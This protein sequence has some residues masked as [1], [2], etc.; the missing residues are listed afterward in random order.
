MPFQIIRAD[1]TRVKVDA[2]VNSANPEPVIGRGCDG[3]IYQAAG[4]ERMLK[5]RK[6]IGPIATGDVAVTKG[7]ALPAKYVFHTVG[8]VWNGG[9]SGEFLSLAACYQKSLQKAAEMK[10]RS[11]AFP[12]IS[13]GVYGFPKD[14]ALEIALSEIQN[15]LEHS[16]IDVTL[17]VFDRKAYEISDARMKD[18]AA[19][20]DDTAVEE[21]EKAACFHRPERLERP[22]EAGNFSNDASAMMPMAPMAP[23]YAAPAELPEEKKSARGSS[24][25]RK[26]ASGTADFAAEDLALEN[27]ELPHVALS[28]LLRM[29]DESFQ[30]R[31]FRMIDERGLTDAEVYRR[32][33]L[34]RKLFS[35]IRCN[36]AYSPKKKTALAF[37]I[38]LGL[39]LDET[40][41]L[42]RTAGYALSSSNLFDLIVRYCIENR[43]YSIIDVNALLFQYDQPLLGS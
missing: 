33:N 11:I 10:L 14:K 24:K 4:S 1:I 3:A 21:A 43:I 30:Q 29:R 15:F 2:I 38:A 13:S 8:P 34:D 20:I 31:L 39:N 22:Y 23:S 12:L 19:Y 17:V 36:E 32:A 40:T 28:D 25:A 42:L 35:K 7:F 5:A 9:K 37:A 41:D 18:V 27:N 26:K 16:E 6:K